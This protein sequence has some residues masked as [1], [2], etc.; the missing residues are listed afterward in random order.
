[1][2]EINVSYSSNNSI[3]FTK[4]EREIKIVIELFKGLLNYCLRRKEN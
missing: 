2:S 4:M 1:M 3:N